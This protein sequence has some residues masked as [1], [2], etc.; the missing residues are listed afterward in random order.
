M[1]LKSVNKKSDSMRKLI[2]KNGLIKIMCVGIVALIFVGGAALFSSCEKKTLGKNGQ[3]QKPVDN[4][5]PAGSDWGYIIDGKDGGVRDSNEVKKDIEEWESFIR[6]NGTRLHFSGGEYSITVADSAVFVRFDISTGYFPAWDSLFRPRGN[7]PDIL[8]TAKTHKSVIDY[9]WFEFGKPI[10]MNEISVQAL[11]DLC[12]TIIK[13]WYELDDLRAELEEIRLKGQSNVGIP[14]Y[15]ALR[16]VGAKGGKTNAA[17]AQMQ[18]IG[19]NSRMNYKQWNA[20]R[21]L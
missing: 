13:K 4:P 9:L 7:T 1:K 8:D 12:D 11:Y 14:T 20:E 15:G 18:T 6:N 19:M 17:F 21:F 16:N 10:L 2:N 5:I 3:E